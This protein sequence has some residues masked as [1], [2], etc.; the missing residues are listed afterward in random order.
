MRE[1]LAA[2]QSESVKAQHQEECRAT[3]AK[4]LQV[5][6]VDVI[7]LDVESLEVGHG[8]VDHGLLPVDIVGKELPMNEMSNLVLSKQVLIS[9]R[10]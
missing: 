8:G 9:W 10:K 2:N 5:D 7:V 1:T 4:E 3:L 6:V